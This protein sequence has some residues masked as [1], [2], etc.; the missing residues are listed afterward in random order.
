MA[1]VVRYMNNGGHS[2]FPKNSSLPFP[3][4]W[5]VS[6][7]NGGGPS[8]SPI[9]LWQLL[10]PGAYSRWSAG[11]W[12]SAFNF[13]KAQMVYS[14]MVA[15]PFFGTLAN[16]QGNAI[17][18]A[19]Q[20]VA[21]GGATLRLVDGNTIPSNAV[22]ITTPIPTTFLLWQP[23]TTTPFSSLWDEWIAPES[24]YPQ[25]ASQ[26]E[27]NMTAMAQDFN[28]S[29]QQIWQ[30][31]H[32]APVVSSYPSV[33]PSPSS[34]TETFAVFNQ[35]GVSVDVPQ[36]WTSAP[37]LGG[38]WSGTKFV[39]PQNPD[40]EEVIVTSGCVGC[41]Y[42]NANLSAPPNPRLVLPVQDVV[43]Q[44]VFN[45]GLSD[46]YAFYSGGN[47]YEGE[48]VVTVSADKRGYGYIQ[49]WLPSDQRS[50]ATTIL[51]SFQLSL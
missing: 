8:G 27:A 41:Y 6:L 36:G 9:V 32:P 19:F 1:A 5:T 24:E 20:L 15:P 25:L 23:N 21:S 10:M 33:V 3:L 42:P 39:N 26:T 34:P 22:G 30:M 35:N 17:D 4:E 28:T 37:L 50:E 48:G 12:Q 16:S 46:G 2:L 51:N 14:G 47:P 29:G 7:L 31:L 40:E 13:L 49:V 18:Q 11:Q 43:G 45:N 38:D 44:F